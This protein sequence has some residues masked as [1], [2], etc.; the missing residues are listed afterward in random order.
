MIVS[1]WFAAYFSDNGVERCP[2][3][4]HSSL[5]QSKLFY[6]HAESHS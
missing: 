3:E 5:A 4:K 2:Q 6:K 1:I